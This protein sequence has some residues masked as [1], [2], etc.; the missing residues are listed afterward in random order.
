MNPKLSIFD[1][2]RYKLNR[3]KS[4]RNFYKYSFLYDE[5]SDSIRER[6]TD[7][8]QKFSDALIYGGF[9]GELPQVSQIVHADI[10]DK[11]DNVILDEE[12]LTIAN[13]SF[14]LAVSNLSLHFVNDVEKAMRTYRDILRPSGIFLGMFLG[15][16]TLIELRQAMSAVD[17]KMH[18]GLAS[19]IIPMID[20]KDA[21]RLVQKAGFKMPVA[22]S[23][24]VQ[25]EYQNL[26]QLLQDLKGMGQGN[27][28]LD[29]NKKYSGKKYFEAVEQE[30]FKKYAEGDKIIATFELISVIGKK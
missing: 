27:C 29:Q 4:L 20:I 2:K 13:E 11:G 14:D 18:N 3:E 1:R 10:I 21:G 6:V 9:S 15:G 5:S 12:D 7:L 24:Y 16:N 8:N 30:Y 25:V 17:I 26:K 19:H 28:L 23:E 22:D